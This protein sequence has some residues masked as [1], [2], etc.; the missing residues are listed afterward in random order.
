MIK[1]MPDQFWFPFW[2]DKWIFGSIRLEFEP[3]ERAIWI[4]LLALAAKDNGFIRANEDTP[5]QIKQLA[6][7]LV[8]DEIFFEKTIQK[9]IEKGKL[10]QDE[11]GVL[12]ITKWDKYKFTDDYKRVLKHRAKKRAV[13]ENV[14]PETKNVTHNITN[15]NKSKHKEFPDWIPKEEFNEYKKMRTKIKKPMTDRAVE[16]AIKKLEQLKSEGHEPRAVL[17]QSI[18]NS[19]QG[20][21]PLKPEFKTSQIGKSTKPRTLEQIRFAERH[22]KKRDELYEEHQEE[23]ANA[24]VKGDT[25]AHEAITEKIREEL[26][27]WSA[28]E[29]RNES[30]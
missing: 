22:Q 25:K 17:E 19:W 21:F 9:Y 24:R 26:A 11:N 12:Y 23:I 6:G 27:E 28:K 13:T 5:Y 29:G 14:S 10:N 2:V 20:L 18:Y 3:E 7:L 30:R 16:L 8:Y 15:H 1:K 4:D